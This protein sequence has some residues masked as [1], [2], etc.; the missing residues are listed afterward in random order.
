MWHVFCNAMNNIYTSRL[1][2]LPDWDMFQTTLPEYASFHAAGRCIS[3][4]PIYITDTPGSHSM[5]LIRQMAAVSPRDP[6]RLVLLRPYNATQPL[7][8]YIGYKSS[9]FLKISAILSQATLLAIFNVSATEHTELIPLRD[10]DVLSV[11]GTVGSG[12]SSKKRA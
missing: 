10:L 12:V 1:N 8:P 11:G 5:R 9:L 6:N 7:S 2:V 4:G 3:G